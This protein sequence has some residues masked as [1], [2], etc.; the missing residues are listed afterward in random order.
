MDLKGTFSTKYITEVLWSHSMLSVLIWSFVHLLTT[1][2]VFEIFYWWLV[3]QGMWTVDHL[4]RSGGISWRAMKIW[5]QK[6]YFFYALDVYESGTW[7]ESKLWNEVS[8]SQR[9]NPGARQWS[10]RVAWP[11]P[12]GWCQWSHPMLRDQ[13]WSGTAC[14][15]S[16][17]SSWGQFKV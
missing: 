8:T 1:K 7:F 14:Q 5:N 11:A 9:S 10:P 6:N 3:C 13:S 16:F 17:S 4:V 12:L 15:T 2:K